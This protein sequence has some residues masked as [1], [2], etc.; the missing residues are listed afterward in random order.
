[1]TERRQLSELST[2]WTLLLQSFEGP[3]DQ[4]KEA[5]RLLLE[6]YGTPVYRYLRAAVGD[7]D[8]ADELYQEFALRFVRGDFRHAHPERGRFRHYLK[9]AL[10]NLI[11]NHHQR[12]R[13]APAPLPAEDVLA[14]SAALPE[15]QCDAEYVAA[16]RAEL[17]ALAWQA[18]ERFERETG[19]PYFSALRLRTEHP[20]LNSGEI[21]A[22][23]TPQLRQEVSAGWVRKQ[24]FHAREEFTRALVRS[25]LETMD[26][27]NLDGLREELQELGLLDYCDETLAAFSEASFR[28][29]V[30]QM[31]LS[32]AGTG[33][34]RTSVRGSLP[35]G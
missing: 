30:S 32:S 31:H 1:M 19:K 15:V 9:T 29:F 18:L 13:R 7:P 14:D 33:H 2:A 34:Q 23:L 24:L 17:L 28:V 12:G 35:R 11:A 20:E 8:T 27:P 25:V 10:R 22:W 5:R 3:A 16:W 6:R 21:A 4:V 26:E